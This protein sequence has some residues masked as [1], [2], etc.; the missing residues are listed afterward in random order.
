[1]K[2]V[3]NLSFL[4]GISCYK[5]HCILGKLSLVRQMSP[6]AGVT[7]VGDGRQGFKTAEGLVWVGGLC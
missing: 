2:T 3:F 5:F 6:G 7:G 1:M 4:P